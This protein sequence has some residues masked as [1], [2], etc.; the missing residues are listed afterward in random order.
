[1]IAWVQ[2]GLLSLACVFFLIFGVHLLIAAYGLD[3]PYWFVLTFFASSLI[4][5]ISATLLLGFIIR[6]VARYKSAKQK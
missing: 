1:M 4:I 6:M 5:L 3:N 2:E